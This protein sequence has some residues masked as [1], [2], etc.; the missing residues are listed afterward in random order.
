MKSTWHVLCDLGFKLDDD[1]ISDAMPGLSF[2]FG[3]FKL[4]AV[5]CLN[6]RFA[7]VVAMS[8]VMATRRTLGHVDFEMPQ[9]IESLEQCAAW[10]V[11][12]LDQFCDHDG[13]RQ[14]NNLGS[15]GVLIPSDSG[16]IPGVRCAPGARFSVRPRWTF[17]TKWSQ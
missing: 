16:V 9:Q 2:D 5:S 14:T 13:L 10:I 17:W 3:N 11:W 4:T 6:L 12:H 15:I 1:V 8:G 7:N